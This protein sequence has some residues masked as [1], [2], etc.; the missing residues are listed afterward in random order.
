MFLHRILAELI[1]LLTKLESGICWINSWGDSPAE[2]P[3]GG[4]QRVGDWSREWS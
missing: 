4:L 2:M 3:V 1:E